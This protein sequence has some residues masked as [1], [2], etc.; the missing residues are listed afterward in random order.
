[1]VR[2]NVEG[3]DCTRLSFTCKGTNAI[4][5]S[6]GGRRC[7]LMKNGEHDEL[8]NFL[9]LMPAG[10]AYL[11]LLIWMGRGVK[12]YAGYVLGLS[13][14]SAYAAGYEW[15]V[16]KRPSLRS[17]KM[18]LLDVGLLG[19]FATS[20]ITNAPGWRLGLKL[21]NQYVGESYDVMAAP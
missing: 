12:T 19:V 20:G 2:L 11:H 4:E 10:K 9:L 21:I 8:P 13:W 1:M 3:G 17:A 6:P 14:R 15:Q 16:F 5:F 7:A 18:N